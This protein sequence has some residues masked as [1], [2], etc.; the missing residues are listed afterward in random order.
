VTEP[1]TDDPELSR[2]RAMLASSQERIKFLEA[3]LLSRTTELATIY[4]STSWRLTAPL[5]SMTVAARRFVRGSRAWMTLEPSS[6]P[7]RAV[8]NASLSTAR[9]VLARPELTR[10]VRRP[11]QRFPVLKSLQ[12]RTFNVLLGANAVPT[13]DSSFSE[14][15]QF[16]QTRLK[17]ALERRSN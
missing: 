4:A 2:L 6:R 3:K 17:A 8:R 12:R 14:R 13:S 1:A 5:R 11:L 10:I 15:E 9:F 7:R 16:V